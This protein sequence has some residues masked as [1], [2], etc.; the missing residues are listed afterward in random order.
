[1]ASS[2]GLR[3]A[4]FLALWGCLLSRAQVKDAES[5]DSL[6]QL[7]S[8]FENLSR[9]VSP[10]V[11][12]VLVSGYGVVDDTSRRGV[13]LIGR[14]RSLG[15]GVI[16]DPTGYIV[17]NAHVIQGAQRI[18]VLLAPR[19][20]GTYAAAFTQ[21]DRILEARIVG[22]SKDV[23]LA[24]LKVEGKDLPTIPFGSYARL[25][26]GE[27]VLA[28]GSPEGLENTMTMGVVSSVLRQPD[29]DKPSIYIQTD[30]AINPGNSGGP[31]VDVDGKM[32]GL[33]TFIYSE[34]G[35][36]EGIG[37]AIPSQVVR[38]A[39]RQI[40]RYGHIHRGEIGASVQTIS[41]D[42][43]AALR[44][45]QSSGVLVS[46]VI[47]GGPADTAG[48]KIDDIVLS[49][50][51]VAITG[52]PRFEVELSFRVAEGK[53]KLQVLR[54]EDKLDLDVAVVERPHQFD[55]LADRVDPERNRVAGL[56]IIGIEIDKEI[57]GLVSDLRNPVGVIVA[58]RTS[59]P[60]VSDAGLIPGDVIHAVNRVPVVTLQGLRDALKVL[61]SGDPVALQI[62]RDGRIS[63]LAFEI[64]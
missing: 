52:L 8:S 33:N 14:Q 55:K 13:A 30:A 59:E 28:F 64:E 29:P 23:D 51:G 53:A 34:S 11:V 24:V 21:H 39:Y 43:A 17:T 37:F 32:V 20:G 22:Q 18:R 57:S 48:L 62:E 25:R 44:L 5:P 36:N 46:D 40:R 61:H 1:M 45:S 19:D 31:L 4:A 41:P 9:K 26:Q 47:P 6:H 49:M 2:Y 42:L 16:V 15:S 63:Y 3:A 7:N 35:G 38:F 12:K 58:A 27:L 54:G 50:D 56:G 60:G 10:A